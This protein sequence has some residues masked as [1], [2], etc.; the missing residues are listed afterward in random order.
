MGVSGY[1]LWAWLHRTVRRPKLA[2]R[3]TPPAVLSHRSS[4]PAT[5]THRSFPRHARPR[6]SIVIP[7]YNQWPH[8]HRCL[9]AVL[10]HTSE[11][12][13]EVIL[14]DDAST[15]ETAQAERLISNVSVVRDGRRKDSS[16]TA[17]RLPKTLGASTSSC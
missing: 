13:Y 12:A 9:Q 16:A 1:R 5:I 15:D 17:M 11:P 8:T 2:W 7:V 6:V 3:Q 4:L 14:A 10:E